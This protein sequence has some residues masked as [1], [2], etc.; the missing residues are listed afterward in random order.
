[1]A[2][3]ITICLNHW[4]FWA[5]VTVNN[6]VPMNNQEH[7]PHNHGKVGKYIPMFHEEDE[8]ISQIYIIEKDTPGYHVCRLEHVC[9]EP[10]KTILYTKSEKATQIL[11]T[12]FNK[13]CYKKKKHRKKSNNSYSGSKNN[14]ENSLNLLDRKFCDCF[15]YSAPYSFQHETPATKVATIFNATPTYLVYNW[16]PHHHLSHFAFSTVNLHSILQHNVF[17]ALPAFKSILFQDLP[18]D[19]FT[20]YERG[21]W[22]II[23]HGGRLAAV[24]SVEFLRRVGGDDRERKCFTRLYSSTQSETYAQSPADLAVFRTTAERV[25]GLDITR[26]QCPPSR[27]LILVRDKN[28]SRSR[29]IVNLWHVQKLLAAKGITQIDTRNMSGSMTLAEQAAAISQYGLIISS[30]SSQLTNLLFAHTHAAVMEL[31]VVYKRGFRHLGRMAG[32]RYVNSVGHKPE[33]VGY[34]YRG[35]YPRLLR[36]CNFTRMGMGD[37]EEEEGEGKGCALTRR[38]V[39]AMKNSDYRVNLEFFERDLDSVLEFLERKCF[40]SAGWI[41]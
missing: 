13:K 12:R 16:L 29:T 33:R 39:E 31:G 6:E 11:E 5:Q 1:M 3:S 40:R 35:L 2:S 21:I 24:E 17:Y 25:L 14:G 37:V 18:P 41:L 23:M 34:G 8:I 19:G 7:Q 20:A 15:S 9:V 30:H 22:D 36:E 28:N 32:L 10:N 38:E 27:A 4:K 26:R